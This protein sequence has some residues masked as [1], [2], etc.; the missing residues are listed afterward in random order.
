MEADLQKNDRKQASA[1]LLKGDRRKMYKGLKKKN[2]G[3]EN[4][5]CLGGGEAFTGL[6]LTD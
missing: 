5:G 3:Y 2:R 1:Y 4:V 6:H